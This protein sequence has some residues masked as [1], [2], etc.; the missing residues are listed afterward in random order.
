[1]LGRRLDDQPEWQLVQNGMILFS[2]F[3]DKEDQAMVARRRIRIRRRRRPWSWSEDQESKQT[4]G[5][6]QNK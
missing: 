5:E 4:N 1:M 6:N 2:L 3:S